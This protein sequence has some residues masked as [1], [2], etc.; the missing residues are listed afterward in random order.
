[1]MMNNK[2]M[3]RN[4]SEARV[5]TKRSSLPAPKAFWGLTLNRLNQLKEC[6]EEFYVRF[7]FPNGSFVLS[8][9]QVQCLLAEK[10]V[11]GDGDYKITYSE[12]K[13]FMASLY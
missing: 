9:E 2:E 11:A 4:I 5:Y 3:G 8:K 13:T 12:L 10:E 1:M 7:D 6:G